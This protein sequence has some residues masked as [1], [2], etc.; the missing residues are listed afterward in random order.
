MIIIVIGY[1]DFIL[2][3]NGNGVWYGKVVYFMILF[4]K[5]FDEVFIIVKYLNS[6]VF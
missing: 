5:I 1:Y 3:V 2:F 6:I 4:V